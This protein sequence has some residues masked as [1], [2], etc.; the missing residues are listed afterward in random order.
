M[1]YELSKI[2]YFE[3]AHT[4]PLGEPRQMRLHGHSYRVDLLADGE[5][6][7]SIGWVV[8]FADMK[9][10]LQPLVK[11][12]DH[13]YLNEVPGLEPD[14]RVPA[15]EAW[16]LEHLKPLP[17]W[18]AGVR[19]RIDGDCF[20]NP[21]PM[22]ADDFE[23]LPERWRFTFEA[24]QSLPSLPDGH[25]CR[26]IHGHSYICEIAA[27]GMP[28]LEQDLPRLYEALD[29]HYLNEVEGMENSTVE[30]IAKWVWD[31]AM[32]HGHA[33]TAVVIQETYTARCV[34]RW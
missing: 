15:I 5:P 33:P 7:A 32:R 34:L 23:R 18:F 27:A 20:F 21:I 13:K 30:F 29:H 14:T 2:L 11:S 10:K 4:N 26:C 1:P 22:P 12:L 31:W 6:D 19:V 16:L 17:E 8:D 24:A 25:A 9:A 28:R 3:A